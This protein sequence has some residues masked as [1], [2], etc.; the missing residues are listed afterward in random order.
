MGI[1]DLT[2]P[3]A[4]L[5]R[6]DEHLSILDSEFRAFS[7]QEPK[8]IIVKFRHEEGWYVAY[9]DPLPLPPLRLA[10][11]AGDCLNNIRAA[12]DHLV[13]QLVLREDKEPSYTHC[14][15]LCEIRQKFLDEVKSP[16]KKRERRSPLRGIPDN[17]DA[18]AIIEKA[19]PFQRPQPQDDVLFLL[20]QMTNVDK[21]RTLLIQRAF[22]VVETIAACIHWNPN[23]QLI[24][25]QFF[26][27]FT[28]EHPT[29]IMRFRFAPDVD[30][31]MYVEGDIGVEPTLGDGKTQAGFGV[32]S[33]IRRQVQKILDQ[34]ATLPGVKDVPP[35]FSI[36]PQ[37]GN[38]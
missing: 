27:H 17:G 1:A 9:L 21:H 22:P 13:W 28:P 29:K 12:L 20:A 5:A 3:R 6:A 19:Q 10:L 23:F 2:G 26:P 4:K 18:W 34:V 15:P 31:G 38:Q 24:E 14:F 25:R 16:P 8:P 11:I 7:L 35:G 32:V 36:F 33:A 30:P 37:Q